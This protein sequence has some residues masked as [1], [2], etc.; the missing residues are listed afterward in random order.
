MLD[1]LINSNK[2]SGLSTKAYWVYACPSPTGTE[3][4]DFKVSSSVTCTI[5]VCFQFIDKFLY[6]VSLLRDLFKTK[7]VGFPYGK[8][9]VRD[10][11]L[12]NQK[13]YFVRVS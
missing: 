9:E 5:G 6:V 7:P 11:I 8:G 10:W 13:V 2:T 3:K 4:L 12:A 1:S